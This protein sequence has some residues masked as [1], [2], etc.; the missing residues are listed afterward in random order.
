MQQ[1]MQPQHFQQHQNMMRP[2]MQSIVQQQYQQQQQCTM[3]T[4]GTM[5]QPRMYMSNHIGMQNI[6][7]YP[8][9]VRGG[10]LYF[11]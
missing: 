1:Q 10:K 2:I 5:V 8:W 4:N 9:Q 11:Y 7:Y 6:G 3:H